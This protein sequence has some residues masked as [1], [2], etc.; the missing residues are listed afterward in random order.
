MLRYRWI[1][2]IAFETYFQGKKKYCPIVST[3]LCP[4]VFLRRKQ[5]EKVSWKLGQAMD[6]WKIS[7][8]N[9]RVWNSRRLRNVL[10][11]MEKKE[12]GLETSTFE[13]LV[14]DFK[15]SALI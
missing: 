15:R 6:F 14:K 7:H 1:V 5:P 11:R 2:L 12:T 13:K 10:W 4:A 3:K 9:M 8:S